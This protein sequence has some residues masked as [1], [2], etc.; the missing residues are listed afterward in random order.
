MAKGGGALD[1]VT[2]NLKSLQMHL[3]A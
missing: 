1:T 2:N 3:L